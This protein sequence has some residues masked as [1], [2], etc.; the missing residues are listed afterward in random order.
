M[1][2]WLGRPYKRY[3]WVI[4]VPGFLFPADLRGKGIACYQK[5]HFPVFKTY[6]PSEKFVTAWERMHWAML[7]VR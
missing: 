4:S 1:N 2:N 5:C 7:L 6:I 3:P